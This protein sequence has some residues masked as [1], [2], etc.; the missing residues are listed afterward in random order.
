M[1]RLNTLLQMALH[2]ITEQKQYLFTYRVRVTN[3][4][5]EPIRILGRSWTIKVG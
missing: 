2:L 5:Q 4:R 1:A 3:L